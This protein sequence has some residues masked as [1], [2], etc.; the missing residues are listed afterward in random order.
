MRLMAKNGTSRATAADGGARASVPSDPRIS[1]AGLLEEV[2]DIFPDVLPLDAMEYLT[3]GEFAPALR[4]S[5][6]RETGEQESVQ[7]M[8][9]GKKKP[10]HCDK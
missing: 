5:L 3:N 9:A 7:T 10:C 2:K 8:F 6:R 4:Y 1:T